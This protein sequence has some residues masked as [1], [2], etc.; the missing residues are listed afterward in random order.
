MTNTLNI[1]RNGISFVMESD[2]FLEGIEN[3]L[4]FG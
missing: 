4:D 3:G 1:I 2:R